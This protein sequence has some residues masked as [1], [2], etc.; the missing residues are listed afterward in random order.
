MQRNIITLSWYVMKILIQNMEFK[1]MEK[2]L[3]NYTKKLEGSLL[4]CMTTN[5]NKKSKSRKN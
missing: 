1:L 5:I 3:R 2:K 4:L